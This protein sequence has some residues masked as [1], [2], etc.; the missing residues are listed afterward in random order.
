MELSDLF[1][2]ELQISV[3]NPEVGGELT[4]RHRSLLSVELAQLQ[5]DYPANIHNYHFDAQIAGEELY[6]DYKLKD[7]ICK[8]INAS[9]LMK[10]IGIEL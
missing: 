2:A 5:N 1:E 8:S 3:G 7:G 6:F 9:I 4:Q 10:K